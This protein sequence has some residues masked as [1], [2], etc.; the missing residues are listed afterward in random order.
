MSLPNIAAST[1]VLSDLTLAEYIGTRW[2][3]K[4]SLQ[5][6]KGEWQC[7][8]SDWHRFSLL[9]CGIWETLDHKCSSDCIIQMLGCL[10][11]LFGRYLVKN[12]NI[13]N[14]KIIVI[15][16]LTEAKIRLFL[17]KQQVCPQSSQEQNYCAL[18]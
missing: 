15:S 12:K 13:C 18:D 8:H 11:V 7:A 14:G 16:I 2:L 6:K 4:K 10:S 9:F 1:I 3:K 17:K 5:D